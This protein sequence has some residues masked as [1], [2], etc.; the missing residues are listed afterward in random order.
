[1]STVDILTPPE[2]FAPMAAVSR[3]VIGGQPASPLVALEAAP[4]LSGG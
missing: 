3:R 2:L 4:T 1:M